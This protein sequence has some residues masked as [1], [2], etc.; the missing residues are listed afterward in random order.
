MPLNIH[1]CQELETAFI[2]YPKS[3]SSSLDHL[4]GE[5]GIA[6]HNIPHTWERHKLP[7]STDFLQTVKDII[8]LH[9]N[10]TAFVRDPVNR[11]VSTFVFIAQTRYNLFFADISDV[12]KNVSEATEEW[13]VDWVD[14]IIFLD[15]FDCTLNDPHFCRMLYP[16]L[17][18]N[19]IY[20]NMQIKKLG[21]MSNVIG[22]IY[23]V[24][25]KPLSV[26]NSAKDGYSVGFSYHNNQKYIYPLQQ[27]LHD[28]LDGKLRV[29][30]NSKLEYEGQTSLNAIRG[31][32][33]LENHIYHN[34]Q[35]QPAELL[36]FIF[37]NEQNFLNNL[38]G[39]DY[40]S[41][42][43]SHYTDTTREFF[44]IHGFEN[45]HSLRD[46]LITNIDKIDNR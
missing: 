37:R 7:V 31:Y 30:W 9:Y 6:E 14:K 23:N 43:L 27:K 12:Q 29:P 1:T 24:Q 26:K 35:E 41:K 3:G 4:F 28:V 40:R 33:H 20:P 15:R 11:W 8:P 42:Q 13:L 21:Y 19:I 10:I 5:Y 38:M 46:I 2:T 44:D 45:Q 32:L 18:L 34:L 36:E 16:L 22:K 39:K 25:D 17:L